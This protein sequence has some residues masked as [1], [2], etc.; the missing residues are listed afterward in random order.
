MFIILLYSAQFA[1]GQNEPAN[2]RVS[3]MTMGY[4]KV[5]FFNP[6][7]LHRRPDARS[8]KT[9]PPS[10]RNHSVTEQAEDGG[11][12]FTLDIRLIL[13]PALADPPSI[14]LV[15]ELKVTHGIFHNIRCVSA[16]LPG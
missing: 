2:S 15:G 14:Q 8:V 10:L 1:E 13:I 6:N 4:G 5:A 3:T 16:M 7:Q 11:K 12:S 9:F